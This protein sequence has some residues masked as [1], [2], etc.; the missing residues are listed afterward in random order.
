MT[1]LLVSNGATRIL[2]R[3]HNFRT[4]ITYFLLSEALIFLCGAQLAKHCSIPSSSEAYFAWMWFTLFMQRLSISLSVKFGLRKTRKKALRFCSAP[5]TETYFLWK[6]FYT[7]YVIM[8]IYF[9]HVRRKAIQTVTAKIKTLCWI[10]GSSVLKM[11][12]APC[13]ERMVLIYHTIQCHI[14]R[15]SHF[16]CT[17]CSRLYSRC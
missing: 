8:C 10:W 4:T 1:E 2:N 15:G 16:L 11:E 7:W 5:H 9:V 17:S 12:A 14:I 3:S 6:Q 13:S